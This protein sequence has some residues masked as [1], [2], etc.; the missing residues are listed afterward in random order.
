MG[1]HHPKAPADPAMLT[2]HPRT[3]CDADRCGLRPWRREDQ[4]LYRDGYAAGYLA[5]L[6]TLERAAAAQAAAITAQAPGAAIARNDALWPT[7]DP[8]DE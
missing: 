4:A 7:E 5:A 3:S 8:D 1:I 2:P 6:Q